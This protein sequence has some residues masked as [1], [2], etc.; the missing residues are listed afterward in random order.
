MRC[1]PGH[2]S[3]LLSSLSVKVAHA[4]GVSVHRFLGHGYVF[5][6]FRSSMPKDWITAAGALLTGLLILLPELHLIP[7]IPSLQ[8]GVLVFSALTDG[9]F[10]ERIGSMLELSLEDTL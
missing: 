8:V 9:V 1:A 7:L 4:L 2:G 5:K 3:R 6:T 10:H